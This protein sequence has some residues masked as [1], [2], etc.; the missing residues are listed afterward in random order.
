MPHI[1]STTGTAKL[2][3]LKSQ[4]GVFL[5]VMLASGV[6][7]KD[8]DGNKIVV[9]GTVLGQ[10]TTSGS[11]L[12]MFGP[13]SSTA[14]D[15]RQTPICILDTYANLKDGDLEV[16]A[17]FEGHVS[18]SKVT[19][20]GVKGTVLTAVKTALRGERSDIHFHPY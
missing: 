8:S 13:Y 18:T 12:N 6:V 9:P 7:S 20:N 2:E 3:Y 19:S 10:I 1:S 17:C 4:E 15:G 16:G 11:M 5:P 14:T